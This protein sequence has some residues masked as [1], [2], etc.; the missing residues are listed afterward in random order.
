MAAP[1]VTVSSPGAARRQLAGNLKYIK[2]APLANCKVTVDILQRDARNGMT[3]AWH[4]QD[5]NCIFTNPQ[6][7]TGAHVDR[8]GFSDPGQRTKIVKQVYADGSEVPVAV[9]RG[10]AAQGGVYPSSSAVVVWGGYDNNKRLTAQQVVLRVS[11]PHL[12]DR[13][14]RWSQGEFDQN[15]TY[16][17]GHSCQNGNYGCINGDHLFLVT[18]S[19]NQSQ[20]NCVVPKLAPCASCQYFPVI[21]ECYCSKN[22][23]NPAM[24]DGKCPVCVGCQPHAGSSASPMYDQFV[25]ERDAVRSRLNQV[26]AAYVTQRDVN[27]ILR[28]RLADAER[29]YAE[30]EAK[31]EEDVATLRQ[32]LANARFANAR[33]Q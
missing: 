14:Y 20:R 11:K 8:D 26:Q 10:A 27:Q 16:M 4:G 17:I 24:P 19:A 25:A 12:F 29:Q 2:D 5:G 18:G 6:S 15:V 3:G 31:A 23:A 21:A 28:T 13:L 30:L 9:V 32:Q 1:V 33:Q 7:A 22:V